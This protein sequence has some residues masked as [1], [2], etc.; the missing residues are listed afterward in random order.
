M[1]FLLTRLRRITSGATWI[2][3]I[4]G[5]RFVAIAAVVI[6]HIGGQTM[7][8]SGVAWTTQAW[9]LPIMHFFLNG[10]RGVQL[11]FVISGFILGRP[12][13][14]Q[15]LL[16]EKRVK[17]GDYYLRRVTRL[18]PPYILN[19]LIL[20]LAIALYMHTPWPALLTHLLASVF[21]L[22]G[23]SYREVSWIN[24]VTWSLEIEIQFYI[25]VPLLVLLYRIRKTSLRRGVFLAAILFFSVF[26]KWAFAQN[27]TS[28]R[29]SILYETVIVSLQFFLSGL[30]LSDIYLTSLPQ[31][32]PN[33][34]WDV[35]SLICWP[36][37]FYVD[38]TWDA[39]LLP[40]LMIV[41]FL[42]AF[43]GIYFPRFF[44]LEGIALIGGMCYSIYLWHFFVISI[45]FRLSKH[46]TAGHDY[47]S[48]VL[49][50][51]VYLLPAV[52]FFCTLYYLLVER[53]CM[54]PKWPRKLAAK[55]RTAE[56]GS[57]AA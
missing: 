31:W 3:E 2:P 45:V 18:E 55:W 15:H 26:E 14:R 37:I 52:L 29:E 33:I 5:L 6:Y 40:P 36:A 32:R 46:F 7:S 11:F 17:L 53:P 1:H 51:C 10:S 20:T 16:G 23:L 49:L 47:L 8:K 42:G 19:L 21:Y 34:L 27:F 12:F 43:R 9:Y 35:A 48:N 22:H 54:D 38:A 25:F 57:A 56:G 44:R 39:V 30:L 41:V 13:A 50:Q 28:P 4:D 24:G